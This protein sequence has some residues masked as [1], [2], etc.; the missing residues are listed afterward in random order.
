MEIGDL[1]IRPGEGVVCAQGRIVALSA[2]ELQVLVA[3]AGRAGHV[4]AREDLYATVWGGVLRPGDRSIDVYVRKL[5]AKLGEGF[6]HT[7]VGFG[8]RLEPEGSQPFHTL[9]TAR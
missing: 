5:R 2:R 3:L 7:H 1:E 9:A 4:V 6:I 8:Y